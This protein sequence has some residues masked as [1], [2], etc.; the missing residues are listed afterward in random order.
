MAILKLNRIPFVK[1]M[2]MVVLKNVGITF[3]IISL[4]CSWVKRLYNSSIHEWKLIPLH[5]ITQKL[6]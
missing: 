6:R 5:I 3:K 4:Q 2:K 1:F